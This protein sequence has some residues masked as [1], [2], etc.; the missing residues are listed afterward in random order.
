MLSSRKNMAMSSQDEASA[1]PTKTPKPHTQEAEKG[2]LK[3]LESIL[4]SA[5]FFSS[6]QPSCNT[7]S[8]SDTLIVRKLPST[9]LSLKKPKYALITDEEF[10]EACKNVFT[11]RIT[12]TLADASYLEECTRL[13]SQSLIWFEHQTDSITASNFLAVKQACLHPLPA[14]LVNQ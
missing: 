3:K 14:S 4:P 1:K 7:S 11:R 13:Q 10:K 12:V 9:L 2:F 8:S 5:V 6:H